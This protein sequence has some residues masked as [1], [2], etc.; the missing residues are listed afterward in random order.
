MSDIDWDRLQWMWAGN[1]PP[2]ANRP[3]PEEEYGQVLY[4]LAEDQDIPQHLIEQEQKKAKTE[5][6]RAR[7][8]L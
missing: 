5:R 2:H 6:W 8:G 4:R 3:T 1:K 7:L